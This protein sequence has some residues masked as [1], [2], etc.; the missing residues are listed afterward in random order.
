MSRA[1]DRPFD[2]FF[3]GFSPTKAPIILAFAA[4][5]RTDFRETWQG[6]KLSR[7]LTAWKFLQYRN[8]PG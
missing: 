8:D 5:K 6:L 1:E 7:L 4:G 2:P 3:P